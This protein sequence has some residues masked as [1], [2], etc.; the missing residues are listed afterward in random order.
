MK[1]ILAA[2]FLLVLMGGCGGHDVYRDEEFK[3]ES[4]YRKS[5]NVSASEAC[6]GAQLAL[7]SQGYRLE[8]A[9]GN[10]IQAVKD[11]Q[12]DE[13]IHA[14]IEFN[15]VCKDYKPGA[16]VFAN[17]VQTRYELK[18]SSKTL[19]LGISSAGS[20]SLPWGRTTDALVKI[21]GETISDLDFYSRFFALI[22]SFLE[23]R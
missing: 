21:S 8:K 16:M 19:N 23:P 5:M 13:D 9:G 20:I 15:V 12:P 1:T 22:Q 10:A 2:T 14:V 18:K 11:F 3:T 4:P 7:L 6:E 17:A